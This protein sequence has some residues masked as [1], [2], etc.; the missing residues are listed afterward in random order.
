MGFQGKSGPATAALS[1]IK[2]YGLIEG[3]DQA[4]K[5]TPLALS[6]LHPKNDL[7]RRA[8]LKEA[9]LLPQFYN[10]IRMQFE[11]K[12]PA[13]QVLKSHLVRV[14]GFNP[15]GADDF[16]RVLKDNR[17]YIDLDVEILPQKRDESENQNK[18]SD[19]ISLPTGTSASAEERETEMFGGSGKDIFRFRI[20]PSCIVRIIFSGSVTRGGLEKTIQYLEL[21]K[22]SY[23]ES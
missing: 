5:V 6:L 3:R 2:Q 12:I 22:D 8:A 7:E 19:E 14:H 18:E 9:A 10:E 21:A 17:P 16:I 1:S 23:P 4:L 11:G 13:D 15:N 20:S